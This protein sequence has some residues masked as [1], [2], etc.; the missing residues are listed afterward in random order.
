MKQ[1]II[2]TAYKNINQLEKIADFFNP[3]TNFELYIHLDKKSNIPDA[4]LDKLLNYQNVKLVSR[5]YNVNW[6]GINHLKAILLLT[7]EALKNKEIAYLHAISGQDFP[8]KSPEY[9]DDFMAKNS[10]NEFLSH[11]ELPYANWPGGGMGRIL[12]YNLYDTL[13]ASSKIQRKIIKLISIIQEKLNFTRKLPA[14]FPKLYGGGTWWTLSRNSLEYVMAYL[15]SNPFFIKAFEHTFCSEEIF[16][17]TVLMNSPF[18]DNII[19]DDLRYIEWEE[20][21][22]SRPA[23]LDDTDYD[24]IMKSNK[25]FARKFDSP[26]SKNILEKLYAKRKLL[27]TF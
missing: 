25:L 10:G 15:K 8:V 18:K 26:A 7:Q 16:F 19:N 24:K 5:E 4:E 3:N 20:R 27:F 23:N 14:N 12:H 17:Q 21:N 13:N 2:I 6:G 1:A 11:V 9:I 22:G